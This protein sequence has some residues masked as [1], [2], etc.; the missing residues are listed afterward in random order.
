MSHE[1]VKILHFGHTIYLPY[2]LSPC[3]LGQLHSQSVV[4]K[5]LSVVEVARHRIG[6][7]F[8]LPIDCNGRS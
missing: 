7:I 2:K 6:D 5:P 1:F 8:G 4:A 3:G